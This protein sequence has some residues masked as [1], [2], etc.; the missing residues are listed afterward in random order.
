M[1]S[2]GT[3]KMSYLGGVVAL[4]PAQ[5]RLANGYSNLFWGWVRSWKT[6]WR[7][8]KFQLHHFRLICFRV[9]R[10]MIFTTDWWLKIWQLFE[11]LL[12][13][14]GDSLTFK[15][16]E[17]KVEINLRVCLAGTLCFRIAARTTHQIQQDITWPI[18]GVV[19]NAG[20]F[21]KIMTKCAKQEYDKPLAVSL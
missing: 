8:W 10:T 5:V 13:L 21:E 2:L 6:N 18:P 3:R 12:K 4:T 1:S 16:W 11:S 7:C 14:E 15:N 19:N 9:E 17:L 20:F